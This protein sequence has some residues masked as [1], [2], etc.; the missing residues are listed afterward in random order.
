MLEFYV[1]YSINSGATPKRVQVGPFNNVVLATRQRA[2]I[3][4]TSG[5]SHCWV[6]ISRDETRQLIAAETPKIMQFVPAASA[7]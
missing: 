2:T 5:I 3:E 6:G 1:N 7:A 4:N